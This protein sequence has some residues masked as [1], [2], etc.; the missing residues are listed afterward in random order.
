MQETRENILIER[1]K[2]AIRTIRR[3]PGEYTL[4]PQ[5]AAPPATIDDLAQPE[6]QLGFDVTGVAI[7]IPV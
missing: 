3:S 1:L 6:E 7:S 4:H 5:I 2:G